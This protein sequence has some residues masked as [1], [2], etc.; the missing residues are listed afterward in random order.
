MKKF[1]TLLFILTLGFSYSQ[2][3]IAWNR[4]D[5]YVPADQAGAYLEAMDEF[6]SNI[7]MPDGVSVSL[8]RYFYKAADVKATHSIVFAGPVDGIIELRQIR[9][10]EGYEAFYDDLDVL[11]AKIIAN[12]AGQSL[13]S[14]NTDADRGNWAQ[15]WQWKVDDQAVFANAYT[16]LMK[17]FKSLESYVALG[18]INQG[19]SKDGE[20]HYIYSNQ[21]SFGDNLKSGPQNQ[22]ELEA[23][24][25]FQKTVAPISTFLGT[26][27]EVNVKT[28]N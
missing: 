1:I 12:T 5:L 23:F 25:E 21:G 18:S 2:E 3:N 27:T 17:K 7:E 4:V 19:V 24:D 28:W 13:I 6:Y 22:K 14:M 8:V 11:D 10:G 9:S 16:E 15:S 20:S 26:R